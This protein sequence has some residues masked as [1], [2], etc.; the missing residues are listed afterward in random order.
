MA[1]KVIQTCDRC[2]KT[3]SPEIVELRGIYL[4]VSSKPYEEY[5]QASLVSNHKAEWCDECVRK[6][7]IWPPAGLP[8]EQV[9]SP[10]PTLED[11]IRDIVR[12]ELPG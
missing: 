11:L 12:Q 3:G 2:K 4:R 6:V 7:G 10:P 1:T 8:P 9:M 5:S